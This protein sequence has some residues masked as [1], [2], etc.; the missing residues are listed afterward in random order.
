MLRDPISG[1]DSILS[2]R[3]KIRYGI[4]ASVYT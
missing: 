1:I 3:D 2:V 4:K